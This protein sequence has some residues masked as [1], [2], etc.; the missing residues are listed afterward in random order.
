M[1]RGVKKSTLDTLKQQGVKI[2]A[3]LQRE[4][5][6]KE[7]VLAGLKAESDRWRSALGASG[8]GS[9]SGVPAKKRRRAKGKRVDWSATFLSLPATFS[10]KMVAETTGKPM[11]QVYAAVSR[12]GKEKK[13]KS[14]KDGYRKIS[15]GS[16]TKQK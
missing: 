9:G 11:E 10:A 13:V 1:P 4:I 15:A 12:W 8:R 5:D 2:L 6:A 14:G 16:A 3:S 7:K